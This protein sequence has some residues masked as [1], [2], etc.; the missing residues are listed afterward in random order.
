MSI[1]EITVKTREGLGTSESRRL[2][3]SGIVPCVVYGLG[4]ESRPVT[5]DPKT[6]N[7]VLHSEKGMNTVMNLRL[8]GSDKAGF[9]MIKN[10]DRHPITS[11]LMHIDFIRINMDEKVGATLPIV[12]T[13]LPEG[14]KLGGVLNIVRHEID[15]TCLPQDLP[16]A[17]TID[18]SGLGMDDA[19]RVSDLPIFEGVEYELEPEKVI[20]VVHPPDAAAA[21]DEEAEEEEIIDETPEAAPTEE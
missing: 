18:V 11:R 16:G 15:V 6:I 19:Y 7:H 8:E 1:P 4:G 13:G 21:E 17:I 9:V 20:A 3:R 12:T 14:V 2:R 10:V 5:V